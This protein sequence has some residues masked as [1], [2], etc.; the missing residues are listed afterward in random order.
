PERLRGRGGG[1]V[2]RPMIAL[3]VAAPGWSDDEL[4]R[5]VTHELEHL[6]RGDW[7]CQCFARMVC[8]FYWFHPL[9]WIAWRR[10]VLEAER[11]CDDAV[12]QRSEATTY[13]AQ[14]LT[15]AERLSTPANRPCV[16]MA[17]RTALAARIRA[18]LDDRQRRGRAG[19]RSVLLACTVSV[20]VVAAASPLRIVGAAPLS[21]DGQSFAGT[22]RDPLNRPLPDTRLTLWDTSTQQPIEA[23]TDHGGRFTFSPMPAGE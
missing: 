6:R 15:L 23:R 3:P 20:L 2:L 4:G 18:L 10:L 5:A 22:L 16:P 1:G 12:L 11:A 8:A 17:D 13:A 9:S 14:L 7:V 21:A 19:S